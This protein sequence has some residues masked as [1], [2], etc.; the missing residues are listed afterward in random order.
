[1]TAREKQLLDAGFPSLGIIHDRA[2]MEVDASRWQW[3][4]NDVTGRTSINWTNFKLRSPGLLEAT[5][6]FIGQMIE[7]QGTL[8]AK[9]AVDCLCSAVANSKIISKADEQDSIIPEGWL[10]ELSQ[11]LGDSAWQLHHLRKWYCWAADNGYPHFDSDV[12]FEIERFRIGG[13]AK[14]QAVLSLD[15]EAGPLDDQEIAGLLNALRAAT[16]DGRLSL[17]EQAAVWLCVA[18]GPNPIQMALL[19][20]EDVK[21]IDGADG[22]PEFVQVAV[23]RMKKGDAAR[24]ADFRRRQ[25]TW[26]IGNLL[27]ALIE[28]NVSRRAKGG[29]ELD[30]AYPLIA[31]KGP[32]DLAEGPM[33]EYAMHLTPQ[34]FTGLLRRAVDK[35]RV[36][37]HRTEKPLVVTTRRLRYT[38]A[39]RLVKEGASK[40]EIADLLDHTDL[41]NVQVYFDVKSDIVGPLDK[42][43]ALAL[44]PIAQAF[45]GKVVKSE[46]D[47]RRGDDPTS[48][49]AV[50]D[51]D[52][53]DVLP[54]GTCG[55]YGFCNLLAPMA[56]YT[57][58]SFQPWMDGPHDVVLKNLL[59]LRERKVA[60][61]RDGRMVAIYDSTILAVADV[62]K[63]IEAVTGEA[64]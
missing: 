4:L 50:L 16:K 6:S 31:R 52:R 46:S 28:S 17:E 49:I 14:G 48:R 58:A 61:G 3:R 39:T 32:S 45:L 59:D 40:R 30:F 8:A 11:L 1:M 35:L 41:Q 2:G 54:V 26:E 22:K 15:P 7:N 43:V 10:Q 37:S 27:L 13:N 25:V 33:R 12:A 34:E 21:V 38:F 57:C 51:P 60:A 9:N 5:V 55:Q 29:W 62:I 64:A 18:F 19:R 24:R 44:G 42:A 20:E 53:D 63:R 56:C 47:A 36:Q 23:P